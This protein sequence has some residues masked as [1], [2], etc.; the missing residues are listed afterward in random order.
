MKGKAVLI[1][2]S[3]LTS[4]LLLF[5][6]GGR[7]EGM[8]IYWEKV[9]LGPGHGDDHVLCIAKKGNLMMLGTHGKG[10][11]ISLDNGVSWVSRTKQEGL[12]WNYIHNLDFITYPMTAAK[13]GK[14]TGTT[15]SGRS[16]HTAPALMSIPREC[17]LALP[18][19]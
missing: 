11:L 4:L 12:S 2:V 9:D 16:T 14:D 17:S 7:E 6:C 19:A 5:S 10:L 8:K 3:I 13:S 15:S 18:T 1:G